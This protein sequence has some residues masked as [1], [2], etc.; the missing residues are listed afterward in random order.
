MPAGQGHD[1]RWLDPAAWQRIV[2]R[3]QRA[4]ADYFQRDRLARGMPKAE[5]VRRVLSGPAVQL[6]GTYF[7][8][9][10][11]AGVLAV[12]GDMVDLPGRSERLTRQESDLSQR[13]AELYEAGGLAPPPPAEVQS[14]LGAKP[15]IVSGMVRY[16]VER[17]RLVR[18]P[19]DL[20][21]AASA[22]EGVKQDLAEAAGD[23][24]SVPEFK[25]RYGLTRKWAIPILEH[26]DSV[27]VTRRLGDVRQIIRRS[28]S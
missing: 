23:S 3:A 26:L 5:A 24:F 6:A 17:G 8:R 10:A 20:I 13:I 18:L 12:D 16:L 2:E 22:I 4:V 19:G 27:G 7:Q 21:I 14:R 25:Q 9:L 28:G 15:Q 11:A 1:A